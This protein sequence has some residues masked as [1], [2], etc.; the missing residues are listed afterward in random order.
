MQL[1][2]FENFQFN[3]PSYNDCYDNELEQIGSD[4]PYIIE[5]K[6][7]K[8]KIVQKEDL[9]SYNNYVDFLSNNSFHCI[10]LSNSFCHSF[11]FHCTYHDWVSSWLEKSFLA[12][13]HHYGETLFSLFVYKDGKVPFSLFVHKFHLI[14]FNAFF[15]HFYLQ[16]FI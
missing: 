3:Q 13:F 11:D 16:A 15:F 4:F 2:L 10:S 6:V 7:S 9:D 12:R 1:D 8:E 14:F 5:E